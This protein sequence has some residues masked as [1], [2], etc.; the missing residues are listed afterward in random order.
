M[1]VRIRVLALVGVFAL[2]C[3]G[4]Q[5]GARQATHASPDRAEAEK[6]DSKV[7]APAKP[8]KS[9]GEDKRHTRVTSTT[10]KPKKADKHERGTLAE[11]DRKK[12]V[13]QVDTRSGGILTETDNE[14]EFDFRQGQIITVVL[15]SNHSSGLGWALSGSSGSVILPEGS[16]SYEVRGGKS[17]GG[18]EIWRFRAARPGYQTVKMEYRRKW[19]QSVPERTFRFSGIVR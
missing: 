15:D 5:K 16:A 2:A 13:P 6:A 14:M 7:K 11:G 18:A 3:C 9:R 12:T 4:C 1:R 19:A 10:P 17:S 8:A